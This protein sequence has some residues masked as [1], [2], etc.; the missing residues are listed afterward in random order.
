MVKNDNIK[1]QITELIYNKN[2]QKQIPDYYA[3]FNIVSPEHSP[4]EVEV[5]TYPQSVSKNIF[6]LIWGYSFLRNRFLYN[7]PI[8]H[9]FCI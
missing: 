6:A 2:N 1:K 8:S 7:S 5:K 9:P 3:N 4:H